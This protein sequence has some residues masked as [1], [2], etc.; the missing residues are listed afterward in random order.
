MKTSQTQN[1]PPDADCDER[2]VRE[3]VSDGLSSHGYRVLTAAGGE[4]AIEH[5][6]RRGS[7]IR[8]LLTD[9]AMPGLDG[10]A[11]I[12]ALR[13]ERPG[14]P[15]ILASAEADLEDEAARSA[16]ALLRKPFSLDELLLTTN[17]ALN[18]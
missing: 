4:E 10:A 11:I 18:S 1:D 3:L 12:A 15:V 14:L 13:R 7:E 5:F 6:Q 16:T 2:A 17:R 8:L 9:S